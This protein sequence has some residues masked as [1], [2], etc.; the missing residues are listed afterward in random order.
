MLCVVCQQ[1]TPVVHGAGRPRKYC[2]T[3]CRQRAYRERRQHPGCTHRPA[4]E[5][6]GGGG[7]GRVL[8]VVVIP[9]AMADVI[10][11]KM[12]IGPVF[13]LGDLLLGV[14]RIHSPATSRQVRQL[15]KE[16]KTSDPSEA[17][18]DAEL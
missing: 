1:E 12:E 6:L 4:P 15:G 13:D 11:Q 7:V 16:Q 14:A 17:E 10:D 5:R 18:P 2:S 8:A 9:A 3:A